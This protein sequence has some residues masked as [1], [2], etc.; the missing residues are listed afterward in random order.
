MGRAQADVIQMK[1]AFDRK[2]EFKPDMYSKKL[3]AVP[4]DPPEITVVVT[5]EELEKTW[6]TIQQWVDSTDQKVCFYSIL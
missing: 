3:V 2:K 6:T 5:D 1:D 4:I